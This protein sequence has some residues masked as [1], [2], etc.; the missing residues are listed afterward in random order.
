MEDQVPIF[1]PPLV[2][3]HF[4]ASLSRYLVPGCPTS[5]HVCAVCSGRLGGETCHKDLQKVSVK[6]PHPFLL[7]LLALASLCIFAVES[8]LS[9]I[10]PK[11]GYKRELQGGFLQ[12]VWLHLK[13]F[14]P[15]FAEVMALGSRRPLGGQG[16]GREGQDPRLVCVSL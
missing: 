5:A 8:C 6:S 1:L 2:E 13:C 9:A 16:C 4:A 12:P 11:E 10:L 3:S 15:L 7:S 14:E